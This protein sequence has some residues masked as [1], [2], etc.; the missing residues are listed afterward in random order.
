M[1]KKALKHLATEAIQLLRCVVYCRVSTDEQARKENNSIETQKKFA[2]RCIRLHELDG[3][4]QV[5]TIH[6]PGY[7]AKNLKRPGMKELI[8]MIKSN[9]VDIIVVYK[10]DRLTR[11]IKDFYDLWEICEEYGVELVSA[12][13][14]IDT[15]TAIGRA[16]LNLL[17]T[18][19]QFEREM[20]SQRLCDKFE[21]EAKEGYK[22]PGMAPYGYDLDK[23]NRSMIQVPEEAKFVK[24]MFQLMTELSGPAAV[25][26]AVNSQGAR[27]KARVYKEGEAEERNIGGQRWTADK[28]KRLITRPDYKAVRIHNGSEYQALWEPIVSAKRW[29]QANDSLNGRNLP[30]KLRESRNKYEL[31]LKGLIT[32]GHCN[33]AMSP[34]PG[35]KKDKD[36]NQRAYY[37]CQEVIRH[38]KDCDCALRSLPAPQ[39]DAFVTRCVG[40][41]GRHPEIIKATI[42]GAASRQQKSLRPLKSKLAAISKEIKRINS[43]L[44]NCLTLAKQKGAGN[45]TK[46]LLKEADELSKAHEEAERQRDQIRNEID[47]IERATTDETLVAEAL[48]NFEDLFSLITFEERLKL[49]TLLMRE[50]R[51]SQIEPEKV[52]SM[53]PE[54][55]V[56]TQIRTSWYRLDFDFYIKSLFREASTALKKTKQGSYLNINGGEGG[57]RTPG[58]ISSTTDF[59][60]VTFGHS[61]TSP[62][63]EIEKRFKSAWQA[64]TE[65][66]YKLW[67]ATRTVW[68]SRRTSQ[69]Q[70]AAL[71]C[72]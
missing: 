40:E 42:K 14:S 65:I 6:D 28:I 72:R 45:F 49:M 7:S 30:K 66:R 52:E 58:A 43:E 54:G 44:T 24:K 16:F 8:T 39:F 55:S 62:E 21:E 71:S 3:W 60:S 31:P 51:V 61:A 46:K 63:I 53:L 41:L 18:F 70:L 4:K 33:C 23:K 34:K 5:K 17:L 19:A 50:I 11:S 68:S 56:V 15:T 64:L 10:L 35:G 32:C 2:K 36:G 47:L 37:T 29:Q 25:A 12:T 38:G 13:E 22:H 59:E 26:K 57:I 69:F 27:T 9:E 67:F 1:M 20:T 48:R